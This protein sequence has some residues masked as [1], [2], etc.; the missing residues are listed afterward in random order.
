MTALADRP[1]TEPWEL[2]TYRVYLQADAYDSDSLRYEVDVRASGEQD[3]KNQALLGQRTAG[4][5]RVE[6]LD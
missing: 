2:H 5:R 6:R 3:A 4:V 1:N